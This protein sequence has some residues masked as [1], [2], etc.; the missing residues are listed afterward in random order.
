MIRWGII[1]PGLVAERFATALASVEGARLAAVAGRDLGRAQAFAKH[2]SADRAYPDRTELLKDPGIDI[3]YIATP[4]HDHLTAAREALRAGKAVLVEKPVC[5]NRAQAASLFKEAEE[6]GLFCMEA[7]W[8]RCLPV[9]MQVRQWVESGRIGAL[10]QVRASFGFRCD[11]D[12]KHRLV[13]PDCAGGALL[14]V[15]IYPIAL[16]CDFFKETPVSIRASAH[17][18]ACGVD[19]Q[20]AL[21][22]GFPGGGLALCDS[23]IRT[24]TTHDACLFG[25]GGRIFIEAP[26][27]CAITARLE[28][29]GSEP[30]R[31]ER[32]HRINGYEYEIEEVV[33][34][35]REG[36]TE[37]PLVSHAGSLR[38]L[39]ILDE[40]RRQIGLEYPPEVEAL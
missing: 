29:D 11:V 21:I 32:P 18:G 33:R 15:G 38:T 8:T 5:V 10:R 9:M 13:N 34:C 26:F 39:S 20:N 12:P 22:L 17:I 14:D 23:A 35:L 24:R 28:I 7:M 1:G 27:W 4:H 3:V 37:S 25:T 2:F 31:H 30:V 6:H 40:A 19:E 36:R 16:A